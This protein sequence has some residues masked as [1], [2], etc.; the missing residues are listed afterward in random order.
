MSNKPGIAFLIVAVIVGSYMV[1]KNAGR[2]LGLI[3]PKFQV[4]DCLS[5]TFKDEFSSKTYNDAVIDI[6][7]EEYQLISIYN[8][9]ISKRNSSLS[10]ERMDFVETNYSLVD[11]GTVLDKVEA[12]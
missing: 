7:I 11:C 8:R 4:G 12:Q 2:R 9:T 5:I 6:G 10:S 3:K 1:Y